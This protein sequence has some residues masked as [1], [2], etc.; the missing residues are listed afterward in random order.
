M[1]QRSTTLGVLNGPSHILVALGRRST[2]SVEPC[3]FCVIHSSH[4]F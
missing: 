4:T 2:V 1:D 3:L